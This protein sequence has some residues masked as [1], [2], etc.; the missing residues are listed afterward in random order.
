MKYIDVLKEVSQVELSNLDLSEEGSGSIKPNSLNK[1]LVILND[2]VMLLH[3]HYRLK[4][5]TAT[6]NMNPEQLEYCLDEYVDWIKPL[7]AHLNITKERVGINDHQGCRLYFSTIAF[8]KII[9]SNS[10]VGDSIVIYYQAKPCKITLCNLDNEIC[11]PDVLVPAV[12]FY[13]ASKV[14]GGINTQEALV[15]SQ[16]YDMQYK[17]QIA[18]ITLVDGVSDSKDFGNIKLCERGFL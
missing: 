5:Q 11:F 18:Q 9:L 12:R 13:I 17:E 14:Y 7:N 1:L 4:I 16:R 15:I 8:N 6:V 2:V 3:T 10:I